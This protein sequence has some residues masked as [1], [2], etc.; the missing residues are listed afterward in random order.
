MKR[1]IQWMMAAILICGT[2]V[3]TACT[4]DDNPSGGTGSGIAMIVKNGQIDYWRQIETAFRDVCQEKGLEAYYYATTAENAY[5]EQVAAVAELRNLSGTNLKGI[6]FA[7]S[8]G[9]NGESAEAEVAALAIERNIP[10]IIL[11]SPVSAESPLASC[12]YFGTDNTAAGK[13]MAAKVRT[14]NIAVFATKNSPG[15]E[16][17]KAFKELKPSAVIYEVGDKAVIEVGQALLDG[18]DEFVFFNGNN[19]VDALPMLKAANKDIYTFDVYPEFLDELIAGNSNFKC[20]I[21]QNTFSMTSKA[22][23]AVVANAK[24]GEV[25]P[26]TYIDL[27]NLGDPNVQP[28]LAFYD[29]KTPV[30]DNLAEKLIGKWMVAD[31]NGQPAPTNDKMVFTFVSTTKAYKS[32]SILSNTDWITRWIDKLESDVVINGNKVTLT[33]HSSENQMAIEEYIISDINDNEFTANKKTSV[34]VDGQKKAE[35]ES[36]VRFEKIKADYAEP[37]L[38]LW[39]CTGLT[40]IETYNDANARLEFLSDGTYRYYRKNDAGQWQAVT[41]REFQDYFVDGTLLATRWK[42]K[43]EDE[44][45]EWWEIESLSGDQMVWTALRQK[46]DGSTVQQKM[47]WKKIDL[48]IP[49]KILGKWIM[50]DKNGQPIPTSGRLVYT[51]VSTTKV[52]VSASLNSRPEVGSHWSGQLEADVSIS[53]NNVTVSMN[54]DEH[55][56]SVHNYTI[57]AIDAN[58]F[59]ASDIVTITIDGNVILTAEN[60][61]RFTKVTAD[62]SADII[63]TWE[64]HCTSA[65]SVFDDGQEHR[66]Q[67][68][69]DGTYVYYVKDGD[70]W[71]PS[72]NSLNEYFVDGNLLCSRWIDQGQ[73]NR[74]WWEINIDGDKMNWTALRQKE[75]GST[76]TATFE[77]KKVQ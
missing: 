62:F 58:E 24:Q 16:R 30:I 10:V 40:G 2:M 49:E 77:M 50:T 34:W 47:T 64:G 7:P 33:N 8:Y 45:R 52:L 51:F 36:V 69:A 26:T 39:E 25:V 32:A 31:M 1:M 71:V 57:T 21:A 75:D 6:I 53:G 5:E 46:E 43:G 22:V 4:N 48:N 72:E 18:Y 37:I 55:T 11:D 27:F 20:I 28:Y 29:K 42:N 17:A 23:D 19:L 67:Y 41:N 12:P 56:T 76:F 73:E 65:G 15:I 35:R 9:P 3:F 44:L 63:G 66:W 68:K 61:F 14:N 38:G 74:E 60:V 59:T 13:E 70:D 54:L